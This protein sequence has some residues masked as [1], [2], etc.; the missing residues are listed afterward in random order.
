MY[1]MKSFIDGSFGLLSTKYLQNIILSA[2]YLSSMSETVHHLSSMS[3]TTETPTF[4]YMHTYM[5]KCISPVQHVGNRRSIHILT[6]DGVA[7]DIA[8]K[9]WD[10]FLCFRFNFAPRYKRICD[11]FACV[12]VCV[13]VCVC[14]YLYVCACTQNIETLSFV[15]GWTLRPAISESVTLCECVS[16]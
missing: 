3:E 9:Y 16:V 14:V 4:T 10:A 11:L 15:S 1:I 12:Y 6:K 5:H 2:R 13:C 8:E 7:D